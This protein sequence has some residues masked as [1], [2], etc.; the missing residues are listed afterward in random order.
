[1]FPVIMLILQFLRG[2]GYFRL[3]H[4]ASCGHL[5]DFFQYYRIMDSLMGILA[6]GKGPV[7]FAEH[8][9]YRFIIFVRKIIR[10]Q[11]P[12]ILLICPVY[13]FLRKS[14]LELGQNFAAV[15]KS[16]CR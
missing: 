12:G 6:P 2:R 10:Y 14:S 1:M 3:N 8:C 7:V 11:K 13:F 5:S 9:G 16:N 4:L 15:M